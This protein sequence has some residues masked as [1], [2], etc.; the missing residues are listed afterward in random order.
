LPVVH[1]AVHA[2][3]SSASRLLAALVL[4]AAVL[5]VAPS[6]RADAWSR[7]PLRV[8]GAD[9]YTTAVE[10]SRAVFASGAQRVVIATGESFPDAL[11]G[12]A[13]AGANHGPL[14][15][16][17][18]ASLPDDV[19]AELH[20]LAPSAVVVMG[21]PSAVSS[22]VVDQIRATTGVAPVRV[23]GA[24]RY[25]TAATAA[26]FY[27][28]GGGVF[29]ATG[30]TF[31]DALG[32]GAAGGLTGRPLL[33]VQH[34]TIPAAT[35][36]ALRR[37]AP[38][39]IT[40]VG[41]PSAV[42]D[43]VLGQL[44]SFASSVHRVAGPD[45]FW[46]AAA[47]ASTYFPQP[48]EAL[49]A[50]GFGFA[51]ALAAGAASAYLGSPVLLTATSCAPS[52][53]VAYLQD[54]GWP[55]V[56]LVGGRAAIDDAAGDSIPCSPVA[57]G[58]LAPGVQLT[59]Y[60]LDGPNVV[61]VV[62]IDR[63]QGFDIR[64][65]LATGRI[66]GGRVPTS[67]IGRRWNAVVAV[68]GDFFLSNGQ[69]AH[70][71][72][73]GG[74][75]LRAPGF[76]EDQT[77]FSVPD[78]SSGYFGTPSFQMA[79]SVV[80]TDETTSIDH[81]NDA[82]PSAGE[83][84]LYTPEGADVF[85]PPV[86]SCAARLT[87]VAPPT[88]TA[89]GAASQSHVVAAQTCG[90]DPGVAGTDD[91]LVAPAGGSRAA[92]IQALEVGQHVDIE[93]MVN[94]SWSGLMDSMGSNTTL[95]HNGAPSDDVVLAGDSTFY[96]QRAPRTAAG[97]MADGRA[98]LVTVDG[99]R[100]GYSVGMTPMEL[101]Q[102]LVS[103]GVKEAANLDGGGSTTMSV[104]GLL[105]NWPSDAAG[106][107]PV[108]AAFVVVPVGTPDPPRFGPAVNGPVE[109]DAATFDPASMGGYAS[110]Q[111]ARGVPLPDE[112]AVTAARFDASRAAGQGR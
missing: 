11:T 41:G 73:T 52:A 20:R 67:Q 13:V 21:G 75:M 27:G 1:S 47:M 64:S 12:A 86:G 103:I 19:A 36:D 40:V 3:R 18:S 35:A 79:A 110:A 2:V 108:G 58:V 57:D 61:H 50:S 83:I 101:A 15:L 102:F 48:S 24:T 53:T 77:G 8:S 25:E 69:P 89:D 56:T 38:A 63:T 85:R 32:A 6:P 9:R 42:S 14:L 45:R 10:V 46:T 7:F 37:L 94:P 84:T 109:S 80:E 62:T 22:A 26:A 87:P 65:S 39:D 105:V 99:R 71:F 17:P 104:N 107:R 95:V 97:Q 88:L 98:V 16:T 74:R 106:E 5:V 78:R 76:V 82:D 72:A 54:K 92:F 66:G 4:C 93:W 51:D 111:R 44:G 30:T 23:S 90:G 81:I 96:T 49:V 43:A 55:N 28:T 68:N 34:D 31:A 60:V 59:T 29:V 91:M 100:A 112:M 33:L 70:G